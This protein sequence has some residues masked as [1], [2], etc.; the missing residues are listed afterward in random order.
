MVKAK[1]KT[2]K[3]PAKRAS[4]RKKY[5]PSLKKLNSLLAIL[6]QAEHGLENHNFNLAEAWIEDYVHKIPQKLVDKR[7]TKALYEALKSRDKELLGATI[8]AEIERL[9]V[10]KVKGLRRKIVNI[11]R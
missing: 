11:V 5:L 9:S 1:R 3:K 7:L 10:L 6:K 8:K 2:K 4:K